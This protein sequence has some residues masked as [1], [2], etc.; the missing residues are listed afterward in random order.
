MEIATD[1]CAMHRPDHL[2]DNSAIRFPQRITRQNKGFTPIFLHNGTVV[3]HLL[4]G[5]RYENRKPE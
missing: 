1:R 5:F 3:R 2:L 4:E